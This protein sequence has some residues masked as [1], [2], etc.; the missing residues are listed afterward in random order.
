[1]SDPEHF[2]SP[3][4]FDPTRY[5]DQDG[6]FVPNPRVIPFGLGKRRCLGETLARIELYMFFTGILSR[7]NVVKA[8]A[9]EVLETEPIYGN[10]LSPKPYK[11]KFVERDWKKYM[12][13]YFNSLL[14]LYQLVLGIFYSYTS[15]E[16]VIDEYCVSLGEKN[17]KCHVKTCFWTLKWQ[18]KHKW[19]VCSVH[20]LCSFPVELMLRKGNL[21][22][23]TCPWHCTTIPCPNHAEQYWS[24]W[25]WLALSARLW[26]RK[27]FYWTKMT[28]FKKLVNWKR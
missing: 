11:L 7:F 4:K 22:Q 6:K 16:L 21:P 17:Y 18:A 10:T 1:M 20:Q 12:L 26:K 15:F 8:N 27:P 24:S 14:L 3:D 25:G 2:P 9:G 28:S 13:I 19:S 23:K 5:L